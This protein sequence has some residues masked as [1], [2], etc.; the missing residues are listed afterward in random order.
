MI[1]LNNYDARCYNNKI[2]FVKDGSSDD[3]EARYYVSDL[4]ATLGKADGLGGQ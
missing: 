4:G 2:Y 3:V 1:L